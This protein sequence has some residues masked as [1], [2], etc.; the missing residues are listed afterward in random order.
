MLMELLYY[1]TLLWA[2]SIAMSRNDSK[3]L[4]SNTMKNVLFSPFC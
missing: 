4:E 3:S 1:N 2:T